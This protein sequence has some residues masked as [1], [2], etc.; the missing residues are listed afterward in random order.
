[1]LTFGQELGYLPYQPR[2]A[3]ICTD[4]L[5]VRILEICTERVEVSAAKEFWSE[6]QRQSVTWW[7]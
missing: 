3:R 5:S 4:F 7:I 1:M 6:L 2:I